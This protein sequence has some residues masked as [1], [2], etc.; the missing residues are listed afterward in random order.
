MTTSTRL[1]GVEAGIRRF[2]A[3]AL[4]LD[5][6]EALATVAIGPILQRN[7]Y[8]LTS[9]KPLRSAQRCLWSVDLQSNF[10]TGGV[11]CCCW[12]GSGVWV[13]AA[14]IAAVEPCV[15][16]CMLLQLFCREMSS[17]FEGVH[18][19]LVMTLPHSGCCYFQFVIFRLR[20]VRQ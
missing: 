20:A 2:Q 13:V 1:G 5:E 8:V 19:L 11:C 18:Q 9:N 6:P 3:G 7:G 15:D 4:K 17:F 14:C 10:V 12:S 16:C